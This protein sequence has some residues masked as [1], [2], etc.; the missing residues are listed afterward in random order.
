MTLGDK[1][2]IATMAIFL[3]AQVLFMFDIFGGV[4]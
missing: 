1:F 3:I 2:F 4:R